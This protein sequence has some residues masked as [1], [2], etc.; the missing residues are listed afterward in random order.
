MMTE[1]EIRRF[2]SNLDRETAAP[3]A[4]VQFPPLDGGGAANFPVRTGIRFLEDVRVDLVA[5]LGE[6]TL[7]VKD[8]L[9]LQVGTVIELDRSAGV[10]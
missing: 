10:P 4:R 1:E 8:V 6:T 3:V 7:K 9:N 5:E 2:L